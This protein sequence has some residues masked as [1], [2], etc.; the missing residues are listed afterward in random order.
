MTPLNRSTLVRTGIT[1]SVPL[2]LLVAVLNGVG[3][4]VLD[5]TVVVGLLSLMIVL[6]MSTFV[7]NSGVVSFGHISFVLLGAYVSGLLTI[8]A[9]LKVA[10][11]P[12]PPGLLD[13]V[14]SGE[15][16]FAVGVLAAAVVCGLVGAIVSV[17]IVRLTGVQAGAATLAVFVIVQNLVA[18]TDSVTRGTSTLIG[19]PVKTTVLVATVAAVVMIWVALAYKLST[20][21]L[22]LRAARDDAVAARATGIGVER[23]R[24]FAF[25]LSAALVG[26]AGAFYGHFLGSFSP[27]AFALP[28]TFLTIAMLVIGGMSS[29]SGATVGV[30]FVTVVSDLLRRVEVNGLGPLPPGK[31]P[32]LTEIVISLIIIATLVFRPQGIVGARELGMPRRCR[33]TREPLVSDSSDGA[34]LSSLPCPNTHRSLT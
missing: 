1:L 34:A 19:V 31:T 9:A 4:A 20:R 10:L 26:V 28:V 33:V 5:R 6:G 25:I 29:V 18:E 16:S 12:D 3:S 2:V 30:L 27:T 8:P 17:P 21:G 23:E 24:T 15:T 14:Y 22:R 7:G 32:G 13:W 11:F